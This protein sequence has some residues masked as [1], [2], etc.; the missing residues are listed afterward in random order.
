MSTSD[1]SQQSMHSVEEAL[2]LLLS[3]VRPIT[4]IES[5][6]TM[7]TLGR[8]LAEARY[9]RINVP[10]ADNS[11]MDGYAV[12]SRDIMP[13]ASGKKE[14]KLPVSQR[15]TAGRAGNPLVPGTAARIFTGAPVPLGADT[16]VMQ[17]YCRLDEDGMV[18]IQTPVTPGVN[19]RY[20]GE[21]ITKDDQILAAGTKMAPQHMGLAASTGL[22][23]L[24]VYR[25]LRV[26][27]FC[28]GNELVEPGQPLK[29]GEIYNSNRYTLV[30]FL[31][32]LGC[33]VVDIGIV[34][35]DLETTQEALLTAAEQADLIIT[36]G[37]VSVGDEDYV[38]IAVNRLGQIEMWKIAIKPGKPL[39][40]GNVR[41]IPIIGLPGNPVSLFVTFCLFAR[42]FILRL[43]GMKDV[44]PKSISAVADFEWPAANKRRQF[45]RGKLNGAGNG[46]ATIKIYPHQGSGVLTSTG[47]ADGL[48]VIPE[49]RAVKRGDTMNFLPFSELLS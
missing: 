33:E 10:P 41:S 9:S 23:E 16:V 48:A 18:T 15:I 26:A 45:L 29:S 37:G 31:T 35:D 8:V 21:D 36:S 7:Q 44:K 46:N 2:D 5:V 11:A 6:H 27:V 42:P 34:R 25:R 30:G 40:F 49:N 3:N 13:E 22:E 24:P 17:E 20:A 19:V 4:D 1:I 32:A 39:A 14:I 47:W 43:Q 28:T 12:A 38:K